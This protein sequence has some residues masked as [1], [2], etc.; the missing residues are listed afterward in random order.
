MQ[1]RSVV[2]DGQFRNESAALEPNVR[3]LD[4]AMRYVEHVLSETPEVGFPTAFPG[5]HV[6]PIVLPVAGSLIP[7]EVSIFYIWDATE[8]ICLSI[9]PSPPG[10]QPL[11]GHRP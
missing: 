7:L 5:V 2:Y 4:D 6:A 3:R 9:K 10:T 1:R 8:T 11:I